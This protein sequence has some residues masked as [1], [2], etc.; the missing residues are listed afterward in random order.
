[1]SGTPLD[2]PTPHTHPEAGTNLADARAG[3]YGPG[4]HNA[5]RHRETAPAKGL[6]HVTLANFEATAE[7]QHTQVVGGSHETTDRTPPHIRV[8]VQ[9]HSAPH[10][11]TH[12]AATIRSDGSVEDSKGKTVVAKDGT[13][14]DRTFLSSP[15]FH[16]DLT[17]RLANEHNTG[18]NDAQK[19]VLN[20]LTNIWGHEIQ[21]NFDGKL[22]T[23][24]TTDGHSIKHVNIDDPNHFVSDEV[25]QRFGNNIP[26]DH[27][28]S[29]TPPAEIHPPELP[30][31]RQVSTA[32]AHAARR[33]NEAFPQ[34]GSGTVRRHDTD[35]YYPPR[36]IDPH[37]GAGG[38]FLNM[39]SALA[40]QDAVSSRHVGDGIRFGLYSTGPRTFSN[41][42]M[43]FLSPEIQGM[44]GQPPDLSKLAELLKENPDLAAKIEKSL[45]DNGAPAELQADFADPN[46]A[47]QFAEFAKSVVTGQGNISAA[48]MRELMPEAL[49]G[50]IALDA[51]NRYKG[52]GATPSDIA[53]AYQLDKDPKA[54]TQA[55]RDSE[56]GKA[57]TNASGRLYSLSG[58]REGAHPNDDIHWTSG[59]PTD[60][61]SI[62]FRLIQAAERH[63]NHE[64][65]GCVLAHDAVTQDVFGFR[66]TGDAWPNF[67]S[68]WDKLKGGQYGHAELVHIDFKTPETS[69]QPGD[70]CAMP[71]SA[72]RLAEWHGRNAG[73]TWTEGTNGQQISQGTWDLVRNTHWENYDTSNIWAIRFTNRETN[74]STSQT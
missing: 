21:S 65:T 44:M 57:I 23:I 10:P 7:H 13:V 36:R 67:W 6:P 48:Q 26:A 40:Q 42:M 63:Q 52:A 46:K 33:V 18:P 72:K 61:N 15:S 5:H 22:E 54:L 62:Q 17:I 38:N 69:P 27:I 14:V 70:Q 74:S 73:H 24:R 30:P 49:Q 19:R 64:A 4:G 31:E 59:S 3:A 50:K 8:E 29:T 1:M 2:T 34:G 56:T 25:A 53:L 45:K 37:E 51:V 68:T 47:Q 41:Y 12:P 32:S 35:Q 71:F 58:A 9:D 39:L 16:E 55:E 28:A 60:P 20:N 11:A 43:G 66:L